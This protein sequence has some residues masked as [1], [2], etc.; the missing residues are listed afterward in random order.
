MVSV[1]IVSMTLGVMVHIKINKRTSNTKLIS[2]LTTYLHVVY[3]C[4]QLFWIYM[5]IYKGT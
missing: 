4:M 2:G 3:D 5:D 1:Y